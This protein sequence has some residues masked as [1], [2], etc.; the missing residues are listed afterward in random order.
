M[1][2][3][4]AVLVATI[5]GTGQINTIM[6]SIQTFLEGFV[7][8]LGPVVFLV[9]LVAHGLG[10]THNSQGMAQWGTRAMKAGAGIV[11]GALLLTV[12]FG[13]IKGVIG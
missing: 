4:V 11:I 13:V 12:M 9:G 1:S 6:G 5:P 8:V 10:S 7:L 2:S 3:L